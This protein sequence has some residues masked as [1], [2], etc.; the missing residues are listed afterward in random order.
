MSLFVCVCVCNKHVCETCV[1][2]CVSTKIK[3]ERTIKM[4]VP[5]FTQARLHLKARAKKAKNE[6]E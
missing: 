2:A 1:Y 6:Y 4:N 3:R 5:H